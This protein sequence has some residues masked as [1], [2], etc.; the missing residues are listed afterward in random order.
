MNQGLWIDA[1]CCADSQKALGLCAGTASHQLVGNGWWPL[2]MQLMESCEI[3]NYFLAYSKRTCG[4]SDWERTNH[5]IY[6]LG[7][8]ILDTDI[9][10]ETNRKN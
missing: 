8:H 3:F 5:Y 6:L 10:Y 9:I 2:G 4:Y 1:L 7:T